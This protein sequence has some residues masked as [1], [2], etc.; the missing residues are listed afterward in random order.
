MGAAGLDVFF[1]EPNVPSALLALDNVVLTPHI[2]S[3]T[4]ET[5]RAMGQCVADNLNSWFDG[6]GALTSIA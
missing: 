6:K 1:D 3:S 2:A 4:D 5:M